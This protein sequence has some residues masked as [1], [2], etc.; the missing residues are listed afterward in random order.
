MF[1]PCVAPLLDQ[2]SGRRLE[3]DLQLALWVETHAG[4]TGL[5]VRVPHDLE[6][7]TPDGGTRVAA[8]TYGLA[9]AAAATQTDWPW[10]LA[11]D[12]WCQLLPSP[13]E[14]GWPQVRPLDDESAA[15]LESDVRLFLRTIAS[16]QRFLGP[17]LDWLTAVTSVVV[18]QRARDGRWRSGSQVD[19][20]GAVYTDLL[21][22]M[23]ILEGLVHESAH[24][25]L[26]VAEAAEPL[27]QPGHNGRYPSPLRPDLRPL[28]GVLLAYHALAYICAFYTDAMN[29]DLA[30]SHASA[31]LP[32][33]REKLAAAEHTLLEAQQ[34][35]TES[36]RQF[37]ERTIQ[38]GRY[39]ERISDPTA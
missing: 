15:L 13:A 22:G 1:H 37:L 33:N 21:A 2:A 26:F 16:G 28:R 18:P 9:E 36:G 30:A 12:I 25:H 24:L 39:S 38:V 14:D 32:G 20:P 7:W 11:L 27:V 31:V 5:K 3:R 6:V 19:L 8:G 4:P 10:P 23:Q 17:T 35:L 29:N 34:Y